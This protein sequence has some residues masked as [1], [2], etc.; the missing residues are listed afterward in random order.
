MGKHWVSK[1]LFLL[2]GGILLWNTGFAQIPD[3]YGYQHYKTEKPKD[4]FVFLNYTTIDEFYLANDELSITRDVQEEVLY[5]DNR[6]YQS[7]ERSVYY[8]QFTAIE[9]LDAYCMYPQ[10]GKYKKEK[11]KNFEESQSIPDD[12]SFYN[13]DKKKIIRF[14]KLREGALTSLHYKKSFNEPF[15]LH[16]KVFSYGPF[17]KKEVYIAKVEDGVELLFT[18]FNMDSTIEFTKEKEGKYTIYTWKRMNGGDK[19]IIGDDNHDLYYL[20]HIVPTVSSYQ[21]K[22]GEKVVLKDLES[23]YQWYYSLINKVKPAQ[24][25][26]LK[27]LADSLTKGKNSEL[28]KVNAIYRWVQDNIKYIA[29]GDGYGGFVPRD[30]DLIYERRFGD[31]KDKSCL[32]ISLLDELDIKAHFTWVGTRKLPYQYSQ[33]ASTQA[34]NHMIATY[35][36]T[37]GK[38]YYLDATDPYL[39]MDK[40]SYSIQGKEVLISLGEKEFKIDTVMIVEGTRNLE[41]DSVQL[42]IK[43]DKVVGQGSLTLKG[44]M[45]EDVFSYYHETTEEEL[46]KRFKRMYSKGSNKFIPGKVS[47]GGYE[48]SKDS[49]RIDYDFE[50]DSYVNTAGEYR[51]VNLNLSKVAKSFKL[52]KKVNV[53]VFYDYLYHTEKVYVLELPK[54]YEVDYLPPNDSLTSEYISYALSYELKAGKVVYHLSMD[55]N[56]LQLQPEEVAAWNDAVKHL[57]EA[58]EETIKL[59]KIK[60]E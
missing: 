42:S 25:E 40:P 34:D 45:A 43:E 44:Y 15:L 52:D 58:L 29:F 12:Y 1:V 35:Y 3:D 10:D 33:L 48:E 7:S 36:D 55:R 50:V 59:K 18:E 24:N 4:P 19:R 5:L 16:P 11:V 49:L 6:A 57:S 20:P 37:T 22:E 27:N 32:I 9:E 30:P 60:L 54:G 47:Y 2:G 31:C 53:P 21:T 14:N 56:K 28:E 23:L 41:I 51:Y 13:D 8:D 17:C 46:L 26:E 38:P 39:S